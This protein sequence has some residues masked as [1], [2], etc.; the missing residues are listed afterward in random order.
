MS[1][2]EMTHFGVFQ[3]FVVIGV[4]GGVVGCVVIK[5]IKNKLRNFACYFQHFLLLYFF[6]GTL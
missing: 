6:F 5:V 2:K 3:L 4:F 1:D